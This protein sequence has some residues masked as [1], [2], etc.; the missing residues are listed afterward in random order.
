[1]TIGKMIQRFQDL[2]YHAGVNG[3]IAPG[4]SVLVRVMDFEAHTKPD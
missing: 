4:R 1:M 2:K 3:P